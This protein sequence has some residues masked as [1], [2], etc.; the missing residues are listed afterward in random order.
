MKPLLTPDEAAGLLRVKKQTLAE[1]RVKGRGPAFVKVGTAVRYDPA[2]VQAYI[3][4]HK[5]TNADDA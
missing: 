2:D 1:W 3:D 4:A 5:S